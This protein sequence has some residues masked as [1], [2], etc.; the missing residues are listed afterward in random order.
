MMTMIPSNYQSL[1]LCY[2]SDSDSDRAVGSDYAAESD[3]YREMYRRSP[4]DLVSGSAT[5]L[6]AMGGSTP[7]RHRL[8]SWDNGMNCTADRTI[9]TLQPASLNTTS[10]D[11]KVPF[12][13]GTTYAAASVS[14]STILSSVYSPR[15]SG[16]NIVT[17]PNTTGIPHVPDRQ[18]LRSTTPALSSSSGATT[19]P[20][21]PTAN[22]FPKISSFSQNY[23]FPNLSV[24]VT[25]VSMDY[26]FIPG[27][28]GLSSGSYHQSMSSTSVS[29]SGMTPGPG[30]WWTSPQDCSS[31]DPQAMQDCIEDYDKS[32]VKSL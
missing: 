22:D 23:D 2:Q 24:P 29:S 1:G 26:G 15:H 27:S 14:S 17:D 7:A 28:S 9:S 19:C 32:Q 12:L 4:P 18:P 3:S 5:S 11:I 8:S 6:A 31:W 21:I 13:Q 25:S 20:S 10:E 16:G 30:Q